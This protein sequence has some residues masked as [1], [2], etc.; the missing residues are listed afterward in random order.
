M[1]IK[2]NPPLQNRIPDELLKTKPSRVFFTQL[3]EDFFKLWL[4]TGG[5]TDI[6][7]PANEFSP[8]VAA[9]ITDIEQR[10][11][12][13]DPFTCD[14]TGFTADTTTITCDRTETG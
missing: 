2:V 9:R 8:N 7:E 10:L 3:M 11:G 14:E 13:G 4:R 12:S 1:P 5:G 6:I